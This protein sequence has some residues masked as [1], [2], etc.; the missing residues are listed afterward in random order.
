MYKKKLKNQN[1]KEKNL[2]NQKLK[3]KIL[4]NLNLKNLLKDLY[5]SQ[6]L[7]KLPNHWMIYRLLIFAGLD[8]LQ[9]DQ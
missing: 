9:L 1:Q 3:K 5:L 7:Y 4:K 6:I 8:L 2:K